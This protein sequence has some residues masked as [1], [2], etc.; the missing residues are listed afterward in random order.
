[1]VITWSL[2]HSKKTLLYLV[3][4]LF[5]GLRS[6]SS[7]SQSFE[8]IKK[9]PIASCT[10]LSI[11]RAGNLYA[12]GLDQNIRKYDT[13]GELVATYSPSKMGEIT[14]LESW[15]SI[16]TIAY[17]KDFQE[18]VF[19]DRFLTVKSTVPITS[20]IS[21]FT[22]L[23]TVAS[24]N[25]IWLIDDSDFSLKKWDI[26]YQNTLIHNPLNLQLKDKD[27][28]FTFIREYQNN[29]YLI[30]EGADLVIFDILGNY[31]RSIP[32]TNATNVGM[33]KTKMYYSKNGKLQLIDLYTGE[34]K[35]LAVDIPDNDLVI[36]GNQHVFVVG[37]N[38]LQIFLIK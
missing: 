27:Y 20:E 32:I 13:S 1:M 2:N 31:K 10:Q 26:T 12:A 25:S 37:E 23:A 24:D 8:L 17:Y 6:F 4:S 35:T 11:D 7:F 15:N 38:Q 3:I 19:L 16:S 9:A 34:N 30:D 18:I 36:M 29:L 22:R 28:N 33:W 5:F 21:G 14:L